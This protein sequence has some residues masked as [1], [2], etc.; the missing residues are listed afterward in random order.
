MTIFKQAARGIWRGR[1]SYI[2][3]IF[4]LSM[5]VMM[6]ISFHLMHLNLHG[7]MNALY[8]ERKFGDGFAA[9]AQIPLSDIAKV[10]AVPGIREAAAT[11]T[12]DVSVDRPGFDRTIT[13]R[14]SSF[15]P[16]DTSRIN[17]FQILE[18]TQPHNSGILLSEKFARASGYSVGDE[19]T[20]VI[21]GDRVREIVTGLV[22]SPEYVYAIPDAS[23]MLPDF[24]TFGFGFMPGARLGTLSGAAG[25]GNRVSFLLE[26]GAK[27][28]NVEPLLEE[29]LRP[30]G[31]IYLIP[32]DDQL[33]HAMLYMEIDVI[34]QM[35]TSM[36][37]LFMALAVI[38]LYIML[39]R[40]IE[41]ERTSIGTLKAMGF[42]NGTVMLLYISYG[43]IVGLLGGIAG[44]SFGL[45][46]N[47]PMTGLMLEF[48]DLPAARVP[49]D[50]S[51]IMNGMAI[52]LLSGASG[53][54][55]G[56]MGILRLSPS[57]AMRPPAPPTVTV[58]FVGRVPF[59]R[60]VLASHGYMAA[61]N[62]SRGRVRSAVV[63][64]GLSVSFALMA[65][66]ASY[67]DM[68]DTLIFNQFTKVQLY[69]LRVSLKSPI[70]YTGA[71]ESAYA[72]EGVR[73]AEG[74]LEISVELRNGHLRKSTVITAMEKSS[75]LFYIYDNDLDITFEPPAGGVILASSLAKEL[76]AVRGDVLTMRTPY[77]GGEDIP[78]PVEGIV[79][80]GLGATG[81][82]AIEGLWGL[83]GIPPSASGIL[84]DAHET[85]PIKDSLTD[86]ENVAATL[87]LD[88]SMAVVEDM[89][90]TYI[91]LT[92]MMQLAGIAIAFAIITNT[93]SISLSERKREYATMRVMGMHPREI[94]KVVAFEY[95]ILFILAVP[96]GIWLESLFKRSIAGMVDNDVFSIPQSTGLASFATAAALCMLTIM[97]SNLSAARK[98]SRFDMVEVLK[99][100]D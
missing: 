33:S 66:I 93:A 69:N 87:D 54:F 36:P 25:T 75:A 22:L 83:L 88:E 57:D 51:L 65:F 15:D 72:L 12:I 4:L 77:T 19:I 98:I 68:F 18:G 55:M 53:A 61:R 26:D 8:E 5:G 9:V 6:Y 2:A 92:Y 44:A 29:I 84:L 71:I 28:R 99:E 80:T 91:P 16:A 31:L 34:G 56:T 24:E 50:F 20:L 48:F 100:R 59:L 45:A 81:F 90:S 96:P 78:L 86:A 63:V 46:L 85:M 52:S 41:Q 42:G 82:M 14:L 17:D 62:I 74:I 64:F 7:A 3:C 47:A 30:Y 67:G 1:R 94:G 37:F 35:S 70:P 13:L 89:I 79:N 60:A 27:Y 10:E 40:I 32:R 76:N 97:L 39:K 95:W 11:V 73:R 21:G 49:P 43:V 38:I 58:D 23:Q